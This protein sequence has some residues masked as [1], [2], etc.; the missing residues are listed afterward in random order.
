METSAAIVNARKH[1]AQESVREH[2]ARAADVEGAGNAHGAREAAV[3]AFRE[4]KA[5]VTGGRLR[6]LGAHDEHGV[7]ANRHAKGGGRHARHIDEDFDSVGGL[8]DVEGRP[9]LAARE[10]GASHI[11][12]QFIQEPPGIV[13]EKASV[14][15]GYLR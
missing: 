3:A 10:S 13:G 11:P 9:A 12:I 4:M 14:S 6:E 2:G 1:D 7:A 15:H 8:D 5:R